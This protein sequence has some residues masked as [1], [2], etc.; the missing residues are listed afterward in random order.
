M[1]RLARVLERLLIRVG[2]S[3]CSCLGAR[4]RLRARSVVRSLYN[5]IENF[6][7]DPETNGERRVVYV[8][9]TFGLNNVFDVGAN[10]GHW[11]E[12]ALELCDKP[13]VHCFELAPDTYKALERNMAGRPRCVLNNKGLSNQSGEIV[14]NFSHEH[15]TL[16]SIGPV[17]WQSTT[18][19]AGLVTTATEYVTSAGLPLIDLLKIDTEG[20][21]F[22]VLEGAEL[23]MSQGR[24]R[25][26]QFEYGRTSIDSKRLLKDYYDFFTRHGFVVGKIFPRYVDFREY[27]YHDWDEDFV[28]P[29]YLAAKSSEAAAIRALGTA[30]IEEG[31]AARTYFYETRRQD[32]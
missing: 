8:L 6:N 30:R 12:M 27:S 21:E 5:A 22:A 29:N 9:R 13:T 18:K 28:G 4:Y 10:V 24:V 16:S 17:P 14:F 11:A 19:V 32:E 3:A 2:R 25:F 31:N 26:V 1:S 20:H 23:L 15:P 7:Y